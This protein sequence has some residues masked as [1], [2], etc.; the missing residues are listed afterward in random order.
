MRGVANSRTIGFYFAKVIGDGLNVSPDDIRE[1]PIR[2]L[3]FG[4][5]A[6]L[7]EHDKLDALSQRLRSAQ[8]H[9]RADSRATERDSLRSSIDR[10]EQDVEDAV[11]NLYGLTPEEVGLIDTWY[12][13]QFPSGN[14]DS[15]S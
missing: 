14:L 6:D 10:L 5:R 13:S 2:R 12:K 3:D 4:T 7:T 9:L 11:V 8:Q 15:E 1:L